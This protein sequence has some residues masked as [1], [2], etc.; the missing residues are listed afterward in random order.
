MNEYMTLSLSRR[1]A[2]DFLLWCEKLHPK[3]GFSPTSIG[4]MYWNIAQAMCKQIVEAKE[5]ETKLAALKRE[6]ELMRVEKTEAEH[7]AE[8]A[9]EEMEEMNKKIENLLE[10]PVGVGGHDVSTV[11]E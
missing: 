11:P 7:L 10:L 9:K 6:L 8:D 3:I 5:N 1:E 4:K 2:I